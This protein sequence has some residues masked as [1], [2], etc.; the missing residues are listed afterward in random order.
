[1]SYAASYVQKNSAMLLRLR[2]PSFRFVQHRYSYHLILSLHGKR[3]NVEHWLN[4]KGSPGG[5]FDRCQAYNAALLEAT[6][7]RARARG[8]TVVLMEPPENT[9]IVGGQLRPVQ[10]RVSAA[11]CTAGGDLR[12]QLL[13]I[14]ATDSA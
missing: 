8:F 10:G 12:R 14:S 13:C 1:M 3:A 7:R 11:V 4:G 5:Q 6:V 2:L 9:A